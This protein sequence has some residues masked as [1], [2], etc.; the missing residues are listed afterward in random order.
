VQQQSPKS[1]PVVIISAQ[2]AFMH[3]KILFSHMTMQNPANG[4]MGNGFDSRNGYNTT[5]MSVNELL[6]DQD[7]DR[8][9]DEELVV[10]ALGAIKSNAYITKL[11]PFSLEYKTYRL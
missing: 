2:V 6:N 3:V 7:K 5:R 9:R 11:N 4:G 10:E 8:M 1:E